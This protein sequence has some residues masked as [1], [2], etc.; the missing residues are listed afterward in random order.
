V[1]ER[2][3]KMRYYVTKFISALLG[4]GLAILLGYIIFG[5]MIALIF[6]HLSNY[7]IPEG[8]EYMY[9]TNGVISAILKC[10]LGVFFYGMASVCPAFLIASFAKNR[11]IVTC[12]P[13]M[14]V[15]LYNTSLKKVTYDAM[16][17]GNQS[18]ANLAYS[19]RTDVAVWIVN[20]DKIVRNS[21]LINI[22]FAMISFVAFVII[23]EHRRDAGE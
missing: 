7:T 5:I 8:M 23:M 17:K 12:I 1:I 22:G 14:I 11:Y 18:L 21:L 6:P 4:G 9:T 16:E 2:T 3:G 15:Y 19:L 20:F 10:L 13:F